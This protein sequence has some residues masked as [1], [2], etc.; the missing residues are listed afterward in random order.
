LLHRCATPRPPDRQ[1]LWLSATSAPVG[2]ST[3]KN[4]G[5]SRAG[6]SV[7]NMGT[8]RDEVAD[9]NPNPF[10]APR[11]FAAVFGAGLGSDP[12]DRAGEVGRICG[13]SAMLVGSRHSLICVLRAAERDNKALARA[14][15][16]IDALPTLRRRKLIATYGATQWARTQGSAHGDSEPIGKWSDIAAP[17]DGGGAVTGR[18]RL[19]NRRPSETFEFECAGLG[20]IVTISRFADGSI[21]EIFLNNGK[22]SSHADS[23]AGF[24][25]LIALQHGVAIS[26]LLNALLRD[27][28]GQPSGPLG[29]ALDLINGQAHAG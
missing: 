10:G 14:P 11:R 22:Y 16:L 5:P 25:A 27:R 2:G 24:G 18:K 13:I 15:D 26:T 19:P 4:A 8:L 1:N 29:V 9:L 6:D 12:I 21:A 7:E 20:Y 3:K 28:R 17:D 23:G